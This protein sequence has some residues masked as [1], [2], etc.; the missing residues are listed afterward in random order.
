MGSP[1]NTGSPPPS[2]TLN[3]QQQVTNADPN[4]TKSY[5]RPWVYQFSNGRLFY[6]DPSIY[7]D[8]GP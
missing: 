3:W 8:P 5:Q 1:A 2:R 4:W 7:V 6:F